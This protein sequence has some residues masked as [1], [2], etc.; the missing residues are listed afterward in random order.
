MDFAEAVLK[1]NL[2]A[3]NFII[4]YSNILPAHP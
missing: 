3:Y 2:Y 1:V 4:S